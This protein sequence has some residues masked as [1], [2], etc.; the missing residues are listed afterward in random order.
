MKLPNKYL[1]IRNLEFG[2]ISFQCVLQKCN[3]IELALFSR[4]HTLHNGPMLLALYR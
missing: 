3:T 1:V 2:F 4:P